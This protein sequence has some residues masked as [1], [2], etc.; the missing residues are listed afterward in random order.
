MELAIA[1]DV[2]SS[3]CRGCS[4]A[5]V[6][7][8]VSWRLAEIDGHLAM[9]LPALSGYLA[10]APEWDG[11]HARQVGVACVHSTACDTRRLCSHRGA[12]ALD[13]SLA[14]QRGREAMAHSGLVWAH[15]V[16]VRGRSIGAVIRV[17]ELF[18][19]AGQRAGQCLPDPSRCD[20]SLLFS[21]CLSR[22]NLHTE[23][24]HLGMHAQTIAVPEHVVVVWK[25]TVETAASGR[26]QPPSRLLLFPT[27]W[28]HVVHC[29]GRQGS[30]TFSQLPRACHF[31]TAASM[32]SSVTY[33][34]RMNPGSATSRNAAR[35]HRF[36]RSAP[37]AI[38]RG[39]NVLDD[40]GPQRPLQITAAE[41]HLRTRG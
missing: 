13:A 26:Q 8:C 2:I 15:R 14:V 19:A 5:A 12:S 4:P 30:H 11:I 24:R 25:H 31:R 9:I 38:P 28:G 33:L 18:E 23:S 10:D 1:H 36:C 7:D 41:P 40:N 27:L 3:C 17:V 21:S 22:H 6:L 32:L 39:S 16:V 29:N 34:Q 37:D 35:H 20:S